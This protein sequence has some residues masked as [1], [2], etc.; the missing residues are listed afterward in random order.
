MVKKK[1]VSKRDPIGLITINIFLPFFLPFFLS[2]FHF[3][4][5]CI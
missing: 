2:F 1:E 3:F 5:L 4:F